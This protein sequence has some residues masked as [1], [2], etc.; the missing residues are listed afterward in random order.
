[1]TRADLIARVES[2]EGA[3]SLIERLNAGEASNALDVLIE[4]ALSDGLCRANSAG[5]KVIYMN[6]GREETYWA[7]DWS[8]HPAE[9]AAAL[10]AA[11]L[12]A[13]GE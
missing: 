5:T 9:T 3:A 10:R 12:R 7:R 11:C 6:K 8:K 2:A 13:G 1:M 4:V